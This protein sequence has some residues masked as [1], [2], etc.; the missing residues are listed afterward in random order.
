MQTLETTH[1]KFLKLKSLLAEINDINAAAALLSWDQATYMPPSGAAARGR[2]LATLRQIAHGK[3]TD[4]AIAQLLE[5][6]QSYAADLPYDSDE[7]SLIRVTRRSYE[8][9]AKFPLTSLPDFLS[10]ELNATRSGQ[11]HALKTI[12]RWYSHTW[13]GCLT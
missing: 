6:L 5:D 12:S 8:R 9:A 3:F 4:G 11:R 13:K 1:P 10:C 2:Q 7:V